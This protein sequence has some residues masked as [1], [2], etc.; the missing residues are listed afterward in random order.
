MRCGQL[1][2]WFC[3]LV[4]ALL[5]GC[6]SPGVPLPPSLELARPVNDLRAGRKGDKVHLTWTI[7]TQTTDHQNLRHG[8]I[9]EVCRAIGTAVKTCGTPVARIPFQA[10][11]RK[12]NANK[13]LGSYTD[14]LPLAGQVPPTSHFVYALSILNPYGRSAGPSNQVQVPAAPTLQPPSEFRAQL[15]ADGVQ[16]SW[17]PATAPQIPGL[18]FVYRIFRREQGSTKDMIAGEVPVS[19]QEFPTLLDHSFEWEK[20]Y[21]YRLTVITIVVEPNGGEQQVEGEDTPTVRVVAHDVFPPATPSGLQ[22]VFSGPG[23]KPFID[24]VWTPNAEPDLAGYNVYRREE[25][26]EPTKLNSDL[27]KSPAF[28]DNE[29]APGHKYVY[30]VSAV[31]M[32]GNESPRSEEATESVPSP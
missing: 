3:L 20:T 7:P 26:G 4:A 11:S 15:T 8:G 10:G 31:D 30:S 32:R 22:A 21:D 1:K 16:L 29:V 5:A 12:A 2:F 6:A 27:I 23:Q 17:S 9:A 25:G 24:L 19:V 13:N 28:R 18:R 14:Q